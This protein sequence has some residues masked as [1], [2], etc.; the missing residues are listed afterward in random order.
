MS[1]QSVCPQSLEAKLDHVSAKIQI[2]LGDVINAISNER[3]NTV[4]FIL[5]RNKA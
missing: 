5:R 1:A 3:D 4:T 2:N